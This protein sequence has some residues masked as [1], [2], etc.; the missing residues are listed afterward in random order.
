MANTGVMAEAEAAAAS[1]VHEAAAAAIA[2]SIRDASMSQGGR[3]EH[4]KD[5]RVQVLF[6]NEGARRI[7]VERCEVETRCGRC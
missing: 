2:A 4:L 6:G 5:R 7:A 3:K 1:A